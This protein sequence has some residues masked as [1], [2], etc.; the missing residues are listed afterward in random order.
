MLKPLLK[1]LLARLLGYAGFGLGFWL[2][3]QGFS[4]PSIGLAF[5]GGGILLGSLYLMVAARR[6]GPVPW[7]ADS[8]GKKE[9]AP[10]DSLNGSDQGG[11][12]P[13]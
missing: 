11:K 3:F 4:R 9:D 13:P 6:S 2:L 5:L 12:L 7:T 1:G 8:A 10:G